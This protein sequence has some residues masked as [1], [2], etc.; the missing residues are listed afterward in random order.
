MSVLTAAVK[1]DHVRYTVAAWAV[2]VALTM[3]SW[4]IGVDHDIAGLGRRVSMV[5]LLVLTFAKA[6]V[7]GHA[8]M[9]H[10]EA[11]RWLR[12][13]FDAWCVGLCL[14][15]SLMYLALV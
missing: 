9:E 3:A 2:L 15:L 14:V 13:T 10:R 7:I 8:F 4:W 11:A 12:V 5:S 1:L 6:F